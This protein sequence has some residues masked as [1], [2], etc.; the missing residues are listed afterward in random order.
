MRGRRYLDCCACLLLPSTCSV[1][2]IPCA[3]VIARATMFCMLWTAVVVVVA[4]CWDTCLLW[5]YVRSSNMTTGAIM[6]IRRTM[7][8]SMK[9][10]TAPSR[11]VE[12]TFTVWAN[13]VITP[14]TP[15]TRVSNGN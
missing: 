14:F 11:L 10:V 4:S 13:A 7:T 15:Q 6:P 9:G 8:A 12:V 1:I 3:D 5:R 2:S